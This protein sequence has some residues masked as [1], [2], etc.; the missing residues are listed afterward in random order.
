MANPSPPTQTDHHDDSGPA[1]WN[2]WHW[3]KGIWVLLI[4]AFLFALPFGIRAVMLAGVPV[5]DDPFDFDEFAKW[6]VPADEDAFTDYRQASELHTRLLADLKSQGEASVQEPQ[7]HAA[8]LENGWSEADEP[9]KKWLELHRESLTVWR[10]GTAQ[11]H[12]LNLSPA[13]LN[14]VSLLPVIQDQRMFVRLA[15]LE[16]AR[17]IAEGNLDEAR[18]WARAAYRSGGHTTHRGCM[19]QGLVGAAIHATSSIGLA[20]W[21]EQPGVTSDQLRQA[22]AET[23][24]DYGLYESRSNIMKAEYMGL[25]NSFMAPNWMQIID[26]G[27]QQRANTSIPMKMG[28]WVIGEPEVTV[29]LSRQIIANQL[30]EIDKPLSTRRKLVGSGFAMLF[31]PDPTVTLPLGQLDPAGIDRGIRRSI[32]LR[33]VAPAFK[34][35]DTAMLRQQAKQATLEVLLAAQAYRRDHGEFPADLSALVPNYL[36]AVPPDPLDPSG[37]PL[38]YRRDEV[39]KATVWSVGDDQIDSGGAVDTTSGRPADVGFLLKS[40]E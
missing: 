21:A 16:E 10:R 6:D 40:G 20:R 13:E 32:L 8:I 29:R 23:K 27:T 18:Q 14:F 39:L 2:P 36:T 22:L 35:Y 9:A 34:Q 7:N 11:Q 24:S 5:I 26:V 3:P 17:L 37:G 4:G 30:A 1:W 33:M 25:R 19:I 15:L 28:Y 12:A 31:D 38:L